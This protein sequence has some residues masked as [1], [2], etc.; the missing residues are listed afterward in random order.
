M[1]DIQVIRDVYNLEAD[2]MDLCMYYSTV[3]LMSID[4]QSTRLASGG[5]L[6]AKLAKQMQMKVKITRSKQMKCQC[7]YTILIK[8]SS[9]AVYQIS[10][11]R[12]P[13]YQPGLGLFD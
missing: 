3:V 10:L 4:T 5:K 6:R 8:L 1:Y 9:T 2:A 13:I 12:I 7:K 11:Y